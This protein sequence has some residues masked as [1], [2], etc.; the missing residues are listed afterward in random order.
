VA[1]EKL[2]SNELF[3]LISKN[4]YAKTYFSG[5]TSLA[6]KEVFAYLKDIQTLSSKLNTFLYSTLDKIASKY[7]TILKKLEMMEGAI[8][9]RRGATCNLNSY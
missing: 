4:V 2:P 6:G 8:N 5:R 3:I 9:K 1:N 7:L